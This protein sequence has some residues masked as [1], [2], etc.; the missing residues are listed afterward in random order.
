MPDKTWRKHVKIPKDR[1]DNCNTLNSE[2]SS[3]TYKSVA[4][5]E[6][7]DLGKGVAS[8]NLSKKKA[9]LEMH[10]LHV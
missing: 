9:I 1:T 2:T 4:G 5:P 8:M 10:E 3:G 7:I 6:I